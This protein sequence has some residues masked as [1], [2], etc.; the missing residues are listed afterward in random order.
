M[1]FVIGLGLLALK[2]PVVAFVITVLILVTI[3][4]V[5]RWIVGKLRGWRRRAAVA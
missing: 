3:A 2:Y 5:I 4:M 1:S